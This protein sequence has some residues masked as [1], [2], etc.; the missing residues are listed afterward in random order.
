MGILTIIP[1]TILY[2]GIIVLINRAPIL[3]PFTPAGRAG[4]SATILLY[5]AVGFYPAYIKS[6]LT[7]TNDAEA[8]WIFHTSP[9][10]PLLILRAARR[11]ILVFFIL[12]YLLLLG[13]AY[14]V[15]TRALLHTVMHFLVIALLVVI[16]TDLQLLFFPEMPF[17]RTRAAGQRSAGMLIRM[18]AGVVLLIP[19]YLLVLLVYPSPVGY[20]CALAGLAAVLVTVR[21]LG[22][23]H[24]SRRLA[25]AEFQA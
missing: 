12:P 5:L 24:A 25:H 2:V 3:D 7:Y 6:A 10:D 4:F 20:W 21:V 22:R 13:A 18:L 11:F 15:M 8:S 1:I 9:A 16:E 23:R 14:A 19:I 17:S